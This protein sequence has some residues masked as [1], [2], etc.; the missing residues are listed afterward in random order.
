MSHPYWD[1][2][3]PEQ[4]SAEMKRRA[5]KGRKKDAKTGKKGKKGYKCS[6]CG[7]PFKDK[8]RLANHIRNDHPKKGAKNKGARST[9]AQAQPQ[10]DHSHHISYIFGKVETIIEY[11]ARSNGV[12]YATL[13]E[14]V[15]GLLRH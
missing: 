11:Y 1:K 12:P 13:A 5:A 14:G 8:Y 2:M 4:R 10:E 6:H 3:T 9:Q 15:A 7:K